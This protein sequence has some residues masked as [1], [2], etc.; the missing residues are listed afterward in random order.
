MRVRV[1]PEALPEALRCDNGGLA[2]AIVVLRF[3]GN[4]PTHQTSLCLRRINY[5]SA[6]RHPPRN[7][8]RDVQF[9]ASRKASDQAC[10]SNRSYRTRLKNALGISEI[11]CFRKVS[12]EIRNHRS[13]RRSRAAPR[14]S[15][16]SPPRRE[17][18]VR[19]DQRCTA[20]LQTTGSDRFGCRCP[21]RPLL[22][23]G[24]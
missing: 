23:N 16:S 12:R 5:T 21:C 8:P 20:G 4:Y 19:R 18:S 11:R 1:L 9:K 10:Q 6:A 13:P 3:C 7:V 15:S 14:R 17:Q 24:P 22:R 2:A